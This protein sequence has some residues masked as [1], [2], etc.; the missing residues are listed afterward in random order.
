MNLPPDYKP[1]YES[2]LNA[3]LDVAQI[4]SV[5]ALLARVMAGLEKRPHV[6]A[7]EVWLLDKCDQ[8]KSGVAESTCVGPTTCLHLVASMGSPRTLPVGRNRCRSERIP[9][10]FET[11]GK[12]AETRQQI[13]IKDA[14]TEAGAGVLD[15]E[16]GAHEN[17]RGFNG[18]PIIFRGQILGV[19]AVFTYAPTPDLAAEWLRVFAD[20]I[21]VSLVNARTFEENEQLKAQLELEN[22][23]LREELREANAFGDLLGQSNELRQVV[24]QIELVAPTDATVLIL[25][26][27]GTGKELVAREI[28]RRS[29]RAERPL[30]RVNCAS[31]PK[32]LY[33]SEF[34]GHAKGSFTGAIKDR[35]GRFEAANGG[36][37]FL[38]EVGEI[39]VELQG[40]LLRV[41]QEKQYERVGEERTRTADVRI[42]AAT[43]RPLIQEVHDGRFR[44]DLY[45]RLN[46]FSVA[47]PPLRERKDDVPVLASYFLEQSAKRLKLRLP[48]LTRNHVIQLQAYN[49][50]GNVRE[51]QNVVE[52]AVILSQNSP[53]DFDLPTDRRAS[54][55]A[56]A[57]ALDAVVGEPGRIVTQ[58]E[59]DSQYRGNLI[60]ALT[61]TDWKI[62]GPGGA[63]ELLGL[64]PSTLASQIKKLEI[65][66]PGAT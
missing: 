26:E 57:R 16:M 3:L 58:A 5:D 45:Y 65:K 17:F 61:Q 23:Y 12:I 8:D 22:K 55:G 66:K 63:A 15:P 18:Q 52:R 51:L 38:D 25:G 36:T 27:S 39:P 32:E 6:A 47:V 11:I 30:I 19:V 56:I 54:P 42:I 60:A 34:F 21:A 1:E 7:A 59:F 49:W 53:L 41:L 31:I 64:K 44:Q 40:K 14:Q 46:V 2:I 4:G 50:P 9:I 13:V 33:E 48:R 20:H 62:Y 28:H 29:H 24:R 35:S 43:N 10:G 37:L